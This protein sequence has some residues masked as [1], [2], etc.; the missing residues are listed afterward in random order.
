MSPNGKFSCICLVCGAK[1]EIQ[2][3][4]NPLISIRYHDWDIKD[5]HCRQKCKRCGFE[6]TYH[7]WDGCVCEKCGK[8]RYLPIP[9]K[10]PVY[11]TNRNII[12]YRSGEV[13]DAGHQGTWERDS[14]DPCIIVCKACGQKA[15]EHT[16]KS[17]GG[18]VGYSPGGGATIDFGSFDECVICGS[19]KTNARSR[20]WGVVEEKS[21]YC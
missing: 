18:T 7:E 19:R 11:G 21:G 8:T 6:G 16:Y 20:M 15:W 2:E 9:V 13:R 4:E 17:K 10:M 1:Y 14:V 5:A 12:C 3:H